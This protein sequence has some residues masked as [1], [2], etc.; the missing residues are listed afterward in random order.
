MCKKRSSDFVFTDPNRKFVNTDPNRKFRL[1][2]GF[3][4]R[5]VG[6]KL[7]EYFYFKRIELEFFEPK[8]NNP[9]TVMKYLEP[10][11]STNDLGLVLKLCLLGKAFSFRKISFVP[12]K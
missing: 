3:L 12:K 1:V 11:N 5:N 6:C 2:Q 9:G 8:Y 10:H 4:G 7:C